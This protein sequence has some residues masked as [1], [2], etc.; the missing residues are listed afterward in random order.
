[1]TE[2]RRRVPIGFVLLVVVLGVVMFVV[3]SSFVASRGAPWW[4]CMTVG[5]LAFP[6]LPVVWQLAGERRRRRRLAGA[7]TANKAVLTGG[8]RFVIRCLVVGAVAIGPVV[9]LDGRS[10][11]TTVWNNV[12][13]VIPVTPWPGHADA[14]LLSH[15]PADAELVI[16]I[17]K[18]ADIKAHQDAVDAVIGYANHRVMA[19]GTGDHFDRPVADI[20]TELDQLPFSVDHVVEIANSFY[21]SASWKSA[22]DTATGPTT[23]IRAL[24][25]KA[26]PN[27]MIAMGGVPKTA[28]EQKILKSVT[29]WLVQTD[30]TTTL[31]VYIETVDPAQATFALTA[32]RAMWTTQHAR[33]P[34]DCRDAVDKIVDKAHV[35]QVGVNLHFSVQI[36]SSDLFG[37]MLCR[38]AS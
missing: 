30:D 19:Y 31:D 6:V 4:L 16:S 25:A 33:L 32:M 3:P 2:Q 23:D 38:K 29:G 12:G 8:D 28:A 37:L 9:A 15:V 13:W 17:H 35:D 36:P 11:I 1:V 27:A 10:A 34:D 26:P 24:L 14:P 20:N 7:K 22:V 21:S 5:A 18:D